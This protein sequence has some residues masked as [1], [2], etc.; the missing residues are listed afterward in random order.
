MY[1]SLILIWRGSMRNP[2]ILIVFVSLL[3]L[4][5]CGTIIKGQTQDVTLRTPGVTNAECVLNNGVRYTITT[6][7]TIQIMRSGQDINLDCYAP[8]NRHRTA[9]VESGF[10]NWST[11]NIT[12]AIVPGMTYDHLAKGLYEYPPTIIVDFTGIPAIGFETP[13]YH[14]K[15]VPNPYTQVI[16]DYGPSTPRIEND[17]AYMRRGVKKIDETNSNPFSTSTQT[18]SLPTGNNGV[19]SRGNVPATPAPVTPMPALKGGTAESLTRS[20]NPA[21]FQNK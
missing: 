18:T 3:L 12:N 15:D 7:E 16:E 11:A 1:G 6:D 9:T 20:A 5:A 10:N 19:E 2:N 13:D 14:N 17:S 4:S 21:V 8:G